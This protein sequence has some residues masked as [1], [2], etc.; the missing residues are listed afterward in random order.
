MPNRDKAQNT[1]KTH[2]LFMVADTK[3]SPILGLKTSSNL[4]LIKRVMKIVMFKIILKVMV[5]V[6]EKL[7]YCPVFTI[8]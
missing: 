3:S 5:T 6:L 1:N 7:G 2:V 4:T 8:L